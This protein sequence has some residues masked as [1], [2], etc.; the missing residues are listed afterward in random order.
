MGADLT[1]SD[2]LRTLV[3]TARDISPPDRKAHDKRG[4]SPLWARNDL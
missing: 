1:I 2:S 3:F 4:V